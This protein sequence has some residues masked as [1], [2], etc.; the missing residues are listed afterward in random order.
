MPIDKGSPESGYIDLASPFS[1]YI[2]DQDRRAEAIKPSPFIS[3]VV[4]PFVWT[5]LKRILVWLS[6]GY[7]LVGQ[8]RLELCY[9]FLLLLL[10]SVGEFGDPR[11]RN[12]GSWKVC[13]FMLMCGIINVA[14]RMKYCYTCRH[15]YQQCVYVYTTVY[16]LL[17]QVDSGCF[18]QLPCS[19]SWTTIYLLIC[20]LIRK[21]HCLL[22]DL[23]IVVTT[24]LLLA[25]KSA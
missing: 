21:Q 4:R 13:T 10:R 22:F 15:R 19:S 25:A 6:S 11:S 3:L 20:F 8:Y 17:P 14:C 24:R 2:L 16:L 1:L 18:Q 7:L 5:Q 23:G 9:L 12:P